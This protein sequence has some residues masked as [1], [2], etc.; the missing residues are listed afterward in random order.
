MTILTRVGQ[1]RH[2]R[3]MQTAPSTTAGRLPYLQQPRQML[4]ICMSRL[5]PCRR[6]PPP[7]PPCRQRPYLLCDGTVYN[8]SDFRYLGAQLGGSFGGNGV[9]TFAV[10]DL[11]GRVA[12]PYDGTGTRISI[13]G[14]P[15]V[16]TAVQ[17][18]QQ[19]RAQLEPLLRTTARTVR[20]REQQPRDYN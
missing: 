12:H 18:S 4:F 13:P 19:T 5:R 3:A 11:R 17:A 10:P 20:A 2:Y 15:I 8:V 16:L 1:L 7:L 14:I 6:T 9:T